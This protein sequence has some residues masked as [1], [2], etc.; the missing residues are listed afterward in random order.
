MACGA[1]ISVMAGIHIIIE[2]ITSAVIWSDLR[3]GGDFDHRGYRHI[4]CIY[5]VFKQFAPTYF[6]DRLHYNKDL[7]TPHKTEKN[8][9]LKKNTK[10]PNC[11]LYKKIQMYNLV[12]NEIKKNVP[13]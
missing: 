2:N 8:I 4:I 12:P 9:R 10:I 3:I 11:L 7:H 5:Q 1:I 13:I 6:R